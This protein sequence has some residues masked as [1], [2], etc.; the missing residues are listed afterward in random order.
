M[1]ARRLLPTLGLLALAAC[2]ADHETVTLD[3]APK[4]KAESLTLSQGSPRLEYLGK[5]EAEATPGSGRHNTG[6]KQRARFYVVPVV[7]DDWTT[8]QSIDAWVT[9]WGDDI[10]T[11][12]QCVRFLENHDGPL[13][14][15]VAVHFDHSGTKKSGWERAIRSAQDEHGI[16][17]TDA[18]VVI[19][20]GH[21]R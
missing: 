18:A 11:A 9:C 21:E 17:S 2:P 12:E 6:G 5:Y 1:T 4:S 15:T 3:Q 14:G 16:R 13:K 19:R 20:L 8:E 10:E 7:T